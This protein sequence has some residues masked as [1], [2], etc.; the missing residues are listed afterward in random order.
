M[1]HPTAIIHPQAKLDPSVQ[2][3]PYSVIDGDVE[4]G[5]DCIVGPHVYITGKTRIGAGNRFHATCV[6]GDAPQDLKFKGELTGLVIGD[7]NTFRE[8]VT[9][10]RATT[11]EEDTVIGSHNLFMAT[12][13]VGHNCVVGN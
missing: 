12:S 3:G 9:I 7:H 1:I 5:A 8:Q 13:H 11:P 6:I 4:M 2:V 10:N